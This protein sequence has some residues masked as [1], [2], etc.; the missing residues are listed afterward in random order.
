M[1]YGR[2]LGRAWEITWRWKALWIL[3]FLVSLG[4]GR[5]GGGSSSWSS[6]GDDWGRSF[7]LPPEAVG[8]MLAAIVAVVIVAIL[9]GIALWVLSVIARGGLI[10]AVQQIEEENTTTLGEAWRAGVG[11]F[12][13]LFGISLLAGLP[14]LILVLGGIAL[15]VLFIIGTVGAFDVS[16]AMGALGIGGTISCF[17]GF[18][19]GAI[20][21]GA[22]LDQ[23]RIYAERAAILEGLGWIEA[24]KRGWQVLKENLGPTIIFWLIFLVIGI[25]FGAVILGGLAVVFAPA[26]ALFSNADPGAWIALP[27]CCGGLL[28][29]V[30]FALI[31]SI[32]ETFTSATWTLAYR[33]LT[34]L[35][36]EPTVEL[37]AES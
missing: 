32:V 23:I 21:I 33:E 17:C 12:W 2:V 8:G 5:G 31:G 4:S 3:G 35:A 15:F 24:F 29:A 1:E 18:I 37:M 28:A 20:L 10:A 34:G 16:E 19:C 30:V 6:S 36:T 11:R 27:L 9:I 22:V 25:I 13:T 7:D 26:I 14:V